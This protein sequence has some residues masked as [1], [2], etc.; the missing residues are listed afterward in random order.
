MDLQHVILRDTHSSWL[1]ANHE[2]PNRRADL[3]GRVL[4]KVMQAL[5]G[6]F[7]LIWQGSAEFAQ[8][9][10]DARS[11][12]AVEEQLRQAS[13]RGQPLRILLDDRDHIR[14]LTLDR[15]FARPYQRWDPSFAVAIRR[16]VSIHLFIAQLTKHAGGQDDLHE[17][18]PVQDQ[19]LSLRH[20]QS[21]KPRAPLTWIVFPSARQHDGLKIGDRLD[22]VRVAAG[23]IK[24]DR[25]SPVVPDQR[26]V[27]RELQRFEPRV[28][29]AYVIDKTVSPA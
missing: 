26:D 18:I 1:G 6:D 4:L 20:A 28:H 21:A 9:P 2:V 16:A 29:V 15:Q 22:L 8:T 13:A 5:D 14:R 25:A 3:V 12:I 17:E 27:A 10:A 11:R 7:T 19:S 23:A 24:A